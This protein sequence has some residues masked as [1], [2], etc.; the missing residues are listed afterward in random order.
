[1]SVKWCF[2]IPSDCWKKWK[3]HLWVTFLPH[4]VYQRYTG[5]P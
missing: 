1:M 3:K 2:E 4:P 5:W